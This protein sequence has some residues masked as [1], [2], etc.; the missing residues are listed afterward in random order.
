MIQ[1]QI[2]TTCI[3]SPGGWK[4]R[5]CGQN[6]SNFKDNFLKLNSCLF[7]RSPIR[8]RH[9]FL[10]PIFRNLLQLW[11]KL[12]ASFLNIFI[13]ELRCFILLY[14]S[15][16]PMRVFK[17]EF[18]Y[19]ILQSPHT[20]TNISKGKKQSLEIFETFR[21]VLGIKVRDIFC[22]SVMTSFVYS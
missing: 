6:F 13:R 1:D 11:V 7:L 9:R 12:S 15:I 10:S 17:T 16:E 18:Q 5:V 2:N 4:W 19:T 14:T 22:F 8:I 20:H 3:F 21:L